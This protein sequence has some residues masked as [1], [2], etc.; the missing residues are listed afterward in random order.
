MRS[1]CESASLM[2]SRICFSASSTSLAGRCFCL[3]VMISMS[4]D[5]VMAT[6]AVALAARADVLLE[7]VAETGAARRRLGAVA[8]HRLGLV[9]RLLRLDGQRNGARLAVDAGE[10][11]LDLLADLEHRAR[12]LDAIAAELGGAQLTFDAV[13]QVDDRAASVDFLHHAPD[14][15]ALGV[16]GDVGRERILGELLDAERDALALRIDRQ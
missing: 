1:P 15:R 11:G 7:Q 5:F 9:V 2:I 10:L 12:V 3:A 13:A 14:D 16:V 6:S 4:S 8:L